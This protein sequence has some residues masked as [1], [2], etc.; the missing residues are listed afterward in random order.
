[1][2]YALTVT[3][4]G[5]QDA[6][7]VVVTD[8]LPE[9][10]TLV[11]AR[12]STS[13]LADV[14]TLDVGNLAAGASVTMTV[15][16]LVDSTIPAGVTE[17]TNEA[18]V[19][20]DGTNGPDPTPLNNTAIDTDTLVAAPD[21]QVTKTDLLPSAQPGQTLIYTLT[22]SNAGN[23]GATG[24]ILTD[25]LPANTS[26][27]AASDGG[28]FAAGVV[29]WNIGSLAAGATVT[30]LVEVQVD[31]AV[32]AGVTSITN[33]ATATDDGINGP[34]PNPADNTA[35]DTDTLVAAP[36]LVLLKDD[37]VISVVAGQTLTY[38][39]TFRNDGNQAATGVTLTDTLPANTSFVSA[40]DGGVL[41]GNVVTWNIGSVPVGPTITR[42]VTVQVNDP[43]PAGVTSII[44]T[45]TVTDDGG[46]GADPTPAN[47][48]DTD[49]DSLATTPDLV[50]TKTDGV[51]SASPGDTLTYTV[52][53]SNAGTQDA[54]GVIVTD[55]LPANT[56][57]V[58]AS[59]GGIFSGGVVTWN[60][61]DLAARTSV[62]RTVTVLV[63]STVAAGVTSLTNRRPPWTTAR[64]PDPTPA[65]NTD[66][67]TDTLV[68]DPDWQ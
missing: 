27:V 33:T 40:S 41:A 52:T 17:L 6:T 68:A 3:N 63:N 14:L 8:I 24:V 59:D 28:V 46:N 62:T 47:N 10:T 15:T 19:R 61:G 65:N 50:V 30:R 49:I 7:G 56:S 42:T 54:T 2:T 48:T 5:T 9:Y 16:V 32:P 44:N 43:L 45:A 25:T 4:V 18:S 60:V 11:S 36:D 35:T 26:F 22:I 53:I 23:Q 13:L 38:T 34:D 39:L 66:T 29:T 58:S 1:M 37:G 12:R 64:G 51:T 55:T 21:L 57:F 67:D 31:T 20:D